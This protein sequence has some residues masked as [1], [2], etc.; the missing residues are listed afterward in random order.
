MAVMSRDM[1]AIVCPTSRTFLGASRNNL[2]PAFCN[3]TVVSGRGFLGG[4][5]SECHVATGSRTGLPFLRV[6]F[7]HLGYSR[8]RVDH[9]MLINHSSSIVVKEVPTSPLECGVYVAF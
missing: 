4:K 6:L 9:D 1:K 8:S 2:E 3:S 7:G 5:E